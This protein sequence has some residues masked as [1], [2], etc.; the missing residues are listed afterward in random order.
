MAVCAANQDALEELDSDELESETNGEL[1]D[2]SD[3]SGE[4]NNDHRPDEELEDGHKVDA[5]WEAGKHL[6]A[7]TRIETDKLEVVNKSTQRKKTK[8]SLSNNACSNY[9]FIDA[10]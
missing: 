5:E 2:N 10:S 6:K 3:S 7:E 4:L 1:E 8:A 9:L